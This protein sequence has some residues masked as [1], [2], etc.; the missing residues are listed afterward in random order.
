[1][2]NCFEVFFV[3]SK[4]ISILL[5]T[6]MVSDIIA[7]APGYDPA[8]GCVMG[9]SAPSKGSKGS[10]R[11]PVSTKGVS[12]GSGTSSDIGGT[13]WTSG[14]DWVAVTVLVSKSLCSLQHCLMFCPLE[15]CLFLFPL[16]FGLLLLMHSF[17]SCLFSLCS[18]PLP[19]FL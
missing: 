5:S 18:L 12:K 13:G 2:T 7:V 8:V 4:G 19:L 17:F 16:F 9:C 15:P 3:A 14:V 11:G 1:M 6:L 10:S